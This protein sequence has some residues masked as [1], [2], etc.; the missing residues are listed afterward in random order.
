MTACSSQ[1]PAALRLNVALQPGPTQ[2]LVGGGAAFLLAF[3]F[4]AVVWSHQESLFKAYPLLSVAFLGTMVLGPSCLFVSIRRIT[5]IGMRKRLVL[6]AL[7]SA[8]GIGLIVLT[9]LLSLRHLTG[10]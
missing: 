4:L 8:T 1:R 10:G 9:F 6:S 5:E 2:V 3:C 7:L